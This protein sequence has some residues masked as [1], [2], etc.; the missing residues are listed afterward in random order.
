MAPII[1][2]LT[3]HEIPSLLE[4]V[5]KAGALSAHY[6]LVRLPYGVKDLFPLWLD[7]HYPSRKQKVLNRIKDIRGGALNSSQF[8]SRMRGQGIYAEQIEQLFKN[9]RTRYG[10]NKKSRPLTIQHF[11]RQ[12]AQLSLL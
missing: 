12:T 5:A 3:D 2:G 8:G 4:T 7:E 6:T 1:P 11:R 10:L 9:A